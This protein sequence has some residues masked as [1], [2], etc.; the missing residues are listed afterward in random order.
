VTGPHD[1]LPTAPE[2]PAFG[3]D[4]R[5]AESQHGFFVLH[6]AEAPERAG[7]FIAVS[8]GPNAKPQ[9]LG[10][11]GGRA[12]DEL[13]RLS[14]SLRRPGE[15]RRLPPFESPSLSRAQLEVTP[16][17]S[18]LLLRNI[19]K[20]SLSINGLPTQAG[21]V[22]DG[23][24]IQ[25]GR[26]LL[27]LCSK[28][29][30]VPAL[31]GD[32]PA[33]AFGEPDSLGI[34]GESAAVWRLRRELQFVAAHPGH[35]LILGATGTGKELVASAIHVLSRAGKPWVAR[36][37]STFPESLVDAELFGNA[38]NYPNVGTPE[39]AGLVGTADHGSLFLDEFAELPLSVQ[40][41][42]LRVLD[43]G[44]YQRLGESAMR[45]ADFRLIAA[46]NRP[47]SDLRADVLTR[48]S[49]RIELAELRERAEDIPLL[50]R[51]LLRSLLEH[52]PPL[53]ARFA[54]TSGAPE[55][56]PEFIAA[57]VRR[58]L[59]GNVRE[60]RNLLWEAIGK[61]ERGVLVPPAADEPR[62]LASRQSAASLDEPNA[63]R[64]RAALE[65]NGG[66]IEKTWRALGLT[67][68]FALM[69]LMK[70]NSIQIQKLPGRA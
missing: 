27:L 22:N 8:T 53:R 1:D 2:P 67:S 52:D 18:G 65:A 20:C 4:F 10:R 50:A 58:R 68:R 45:R 5:G 43:D 24:L 13:V 61:S 44:E 63:A 49:F 59:P 28:Q 55:L 37:A 21:T 33:H 41:H 35:V 25:V 48:F 40:T 62:E 14:A 23:D 19:G 39:R 47:T 32:P 6:C 38:R 66:S 12:D 56:G 31:A 30:F 64:L 34:V 26:Q 9:I 69:R 7:A 46:T 70:K 3:G 57:L 42:L 29:T 54:G 60:L 11:G 17:P 15:N 36:N 51:H 16:T